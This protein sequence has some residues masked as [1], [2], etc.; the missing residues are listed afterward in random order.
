M[1]SYFIAVNAMTI[2]AKG[3]P[4]LHWATVVTV[5]TS[6][7]VGVGTGY[8]LQRRISQAAALRVTVW[9]AALGALA[10]GIRGLVLIA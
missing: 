3:M 8:F 10:V 1:W 2:A 9:V 7:A 4:A 6:I 5:V